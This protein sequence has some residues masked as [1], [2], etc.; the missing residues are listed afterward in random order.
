[1]DQNRLISTS[2]AVDPVFIFLFATCL[3]LFL[4]IAVTMVI[5]VSR[6]H[7]S[8]APLPTSQV[9]SNFWLEFVWTL[10]PTLLVMAMFWYGWKEY[11]VLRTVPKGAMA[12][13]ATARTWSWSFSYAN[14][15]TSPKLYVPIGRPVSVDLVSL[16]VI[17]GIFV[18]AFR[19]KR[20]IVPGMKNHIWFV[21]DR[22]GSYDLFCSQHCGTGHASMITTVEALPAEDFARWLQ[23]GATQGS[24]AKPDGRNLVSDKGCLAC[25]TLDGSTGIGPT[26]KGIM[27]RQVTVVSGEKERTVTVD[28]EYLRRAVNDPRADVV[29]GFQPIMPAY[30]DLS[31]EEL[32]ALVEFLKGVR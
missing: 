18:P 31:P 8:R 5:F 3:V 28:E 25:H 17:H 9:E 23:E 32:Q 24:V 26:F 27:G 4:G 6:Y 22:P 20:D 21:A 10:L 14:G 16:D 30:T 13:T 1:M 15:K 29:K 7:R 2:D 11:L 12:V 19:V